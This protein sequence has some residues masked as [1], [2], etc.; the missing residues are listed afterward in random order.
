MSGYK[1]PDFEIANRLCDEIV[2]FLL[3]C[4][5]VYDRTNQGIVNRL[6][7]NVL[8]S[9][10]TGQ[11]LYRQDGYYLSYWKVSPEDV[12][13]LKDRMEI[14]NRT[15]GTVM[16]I[17]ECGIKGNWMLEISKKLRVAGKGMQG[18]FWHR[19]SKADKV[20]DFPSQK[21]ASH[22]R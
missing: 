15:F 20:Y 17:A 13:D 4:G 11:F 8:F 9:I 3:D 10:A 16:Y 14:E 19:P 1:S 21:G 18:I 2:E 12:Q 6:I 22:G 7:E 5:G